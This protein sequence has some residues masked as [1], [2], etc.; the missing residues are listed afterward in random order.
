MQIANIIESFFFSQ[1]IIEKHCSAAGD[2]ENVFDP[3]IGK[4]FEN[5]ICYSHFPQNSLI[6]AIIYSSFSSVIPG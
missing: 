6:L 2:G 5:V 3:L 4:K 1:S